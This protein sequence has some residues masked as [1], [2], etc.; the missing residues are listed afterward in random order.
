M[1]GSKGIS[2][3]SATGAAWLAALV[4]AFAVLVSM[5]PLIDAGA[6]VLTIG[7]LFTDDAFAHDVIA[8]NLA[9][10]GAPSLDGQHLTDGFPPLWMALLTAVK[11]LSG[12][13]VAP[14]FLTLGYL[15]APLAAAG[16]AFYIMLGGDESDFFDGAALSGA[17]GQATALATLAFLA[18]SFLHTP[19][20]ARLLAGG[21]SVLVVLLLALWLIAARRVIC[22]AARLPGVAGFAA[23]SAA[24]MLA[25]GDLFWMPAAALVFLL[26]RFGVGRALALGAAIIA[27]MLAP[28]LAWTIAST[29]SP[30]PISLPVTRFYIAETLPSAAAYWA[31][32]EW[33]ALP[34]LFARIYGIGLLPLGVILGATILAFANGR[35]RAMLP[36]ELWLLAGICVLHVA[37]LYAVFRGLGPER[38]ALFLPELLLTLLIATH[39]MRGALIRLRPGLAAPRAGGMAVPAGA[40][41]ALAAISPQPVPGENPDWLARLT[42][43][44][45]IARVVPEGE[46]VGAFWP[47]LIAA[48]SDRPVIPLDG[49]FADR[50]WLT[51]TLMQRREFDAALEAGAR[52][53]ALYF[54]AGYAENTH[55]PLAPDWRMLYL[56]RLE[57]AGHIGTA[58]VIPRVSGPG[59]AG[60]YLLRLT[61]PEG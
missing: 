56:E 35:F 48:V 5:A 21:G 41:F 58:V 27:L 11:Y 55:V 54:P 38:D 31:S 1:A 60:W 49:R 13:P 50:P 40:A 17:G 22:P 39:L 44:E 61:P 9:A 12:D 25:R 26:A 4:A 37:G 57:D 51:D 28:W 46:P 14:A 6:R 45:D 16:F 52:H 53:V 24:L 47:G 23:A 43:A 42:I 29:G 59:G 34:A 36:R 3:R 30:F 7:G 19:F 2:S 8:R 20:L 18:A 10:G 33:R 32:D 15:I